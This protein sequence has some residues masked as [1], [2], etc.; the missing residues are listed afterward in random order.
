M[1]LAG[2]IIVEGK[3]PIIGRYEVVPGDPMAFV[4]RAEGPTS[5]FQN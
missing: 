3:G 4:D 2:V 1:Q 5:I